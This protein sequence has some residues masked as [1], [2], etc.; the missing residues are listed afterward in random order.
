MSTCSSGLPSWRG[1]NVENFSKT[2]I[3]PLTSRPIRDIHSPMA[4]FPMM[5]G[6]WIMQR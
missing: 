6:A 3:S 4:I 2:G 1:G 5:E